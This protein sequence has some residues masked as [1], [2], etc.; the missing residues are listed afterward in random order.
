MHRRYSEFEDLREE[1]LEM[2][3]LY[4]SARL[5]PLATLPFPQKRW[6]GSNS[7]EV[8][9]DRKAGLEVWLNG[10]IELVVRF[11]TEI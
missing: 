1:L 8:I 4:P 5:E 7:A 6:I 11:W 2:I 10:V 9:S 3:A